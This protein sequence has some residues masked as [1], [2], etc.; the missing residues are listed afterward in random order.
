MKRKLVLIAT[1]VALV[2]LGIPAIA[3]AQN[4]ESQKAVRPHLKGAVDVVAPHVAPVNEQ[5]QMTVFYSVNQTTVEGAGVWAVSADKIEVVK[6]EIEAIE[7]K[8][9][10]EIAAAAEQVLDV[11]ANLLGR[12]GPDGK[13][14]YTFMKEGR[15][16]LVAF[17]PGFCP[18]L[19]PIA[20][21]VLPAARPALVIETP[22][23]AGPGEKFDVTVT[24]KRTG[25]AV[26]DAK[27][28]ALSPE[29]AEA[30]KA[31]MDTLKQNT[32][33]NSLEAAV[34]NT[35]AISGVFLGSTNGAGKLEP[36]PSLE[37]AGVYVLVTFKPGFWPAWRAILIASA[38]KVL[39]IDAPN[40]ARVNEKVA[41]TVTEKADGKAVQDAGV[42]ALN[43]QQA[44]SLKAQVEGL[45]KSTADQATLQAEIENALRVSGIFLGSTNGA[46]RLEPQPSFPTAGG[47]LLV[48]YKPG[49]WP[50]MRPIVIVNPQ[51]TRPGIDRV[52]TTN[53]DI[54]KS[55]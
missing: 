19:R 5:V 21:G 16:L 55:R 44:E 37:D 25:D 39:V 35:L 15:Y 18:D 8:A 20:I 46:G 33:A 26:K 9:A 45:R 48:A 36:Q 2:A 28:W 54:A 31:Q 30:V 40:R 23:R 29:K 53:A 27:V 32:G 38:P 51:T 42:W 50:A 7:N 43:R 24:E 49:Y 3:L 14:L 11:H 10:N 13:I 4:Q 34:E 47:Y 41:I 22:R 1:A 6:R 17:K 52:P 12:T